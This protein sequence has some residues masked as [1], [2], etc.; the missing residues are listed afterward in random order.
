MPDN[1]TA[2]KVV[3]PGGPKFRTDVDVDIHTPVQKIQLGNED[4]FDGFVSVTNP[5]PVTDP[6]D[7]ITQGIRT[8]VSQW[9]KFG[10][11]TASTAAGGD[12]T[13]WASNDDLTILTTAS[14][15]TIAYNNA[16][17]GVGNT[18]VTL[19]QFF[20][21]DA[22]EEMAVAVHTLGSSGSDV[23]SFTGLGVNRCVVVGSGTNNTNANNVT[24]TA[25]T[26]GTTQAVIPANEGVTQQSVFFM[27]NNAVGSLKMLMLNANDDAGGL[28]PYIR[29]KGFVYNRTVSSQFEIFRYL[30]DT[31]LEES[32][33]LID[34]VNFSL[35]PRD[36]LFFTMDTS[37]D[38]TE[39]TCR[40]SIHL[41][42]N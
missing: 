38:N 16:T 23:T 19:L 17:D 24:I 15:F 3:T 37:R 31:A 27:P 11:R 20:Y 35:S 42:N 13:I 30:M 29:F 18:G 22:N 9:N 10:Y 26:G 28:A 6:A 21:L 4:S 25:T 8:G 12:E 7:D 39:A 2:E 1:V 41:Y 40:F 36:V 34:P 33:L 14:T 5:M 32:F